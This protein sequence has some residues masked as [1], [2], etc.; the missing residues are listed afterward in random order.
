MQ[1]RLINMGKWLDVNGEAIYETRRWKK[2]CQWSEGTIIEYTKQEFHKGVPDPIIEMARYPRE[3]QAR[4]ECYFTNKG[5][6]VY[7]LITQLPDNGTFT[8][9]DIEL[10]PESQ[11]SMLGFEGSLDYSAH[12]GKVT[13][14]LPAFNPSTMPCDFVYTL[15]LTQA[16]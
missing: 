1:D 9:R 15:K 5:D 7:A 16:R 3:G 10:S 11:V 2:D 4:K 8:I 13:V 14:T 6:T 12:E